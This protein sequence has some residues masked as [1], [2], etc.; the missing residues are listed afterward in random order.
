MMLVLALI[1]AVALFLVLVLLGEDHHE[2]VVDLLR[3]VMY[4]LVMVALVAVG[5]RLVLSI[6][7][8]P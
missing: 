2:M 8:M 5:A 4:A 1:L 7:P 3:G 6:L